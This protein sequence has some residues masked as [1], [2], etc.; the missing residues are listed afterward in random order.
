MGTC[1]VV[2]LSENLPFARDRRIKREALALKE[3]GYKVSV[4]CPRDSEKESAS[5]VSIDGVS[6]HSYGQPWQGSGIFS[7]FLEY[8]WAILCSFSILAWIWSADDVDILH[9]ANPPDLFFL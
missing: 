8:S 1:H 4:V 5:R 2:L 9:A 3:A 7:Y 6:V